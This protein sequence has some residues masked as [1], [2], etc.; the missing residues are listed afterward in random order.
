M[1]ATFNRL[2]FIC[3]RYRGDVETNVL[4][5]KYLCMTATQQGLVPVAPHLLYP[6]F[7]NDASEDER[8]VGMTCGMLLLERCDEMWVYTHAGVSGGMLAEIEHA[9]R[10][11]IPINMN[12]L[13]GADRAVLNNFLAGAKKPTEKATSVQCQT[14]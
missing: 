10:R 9:A 4:T 5:A 12:P 1:A 3:S 6:Q 14:E 2:V 8:T 7:L 13:T 11:D